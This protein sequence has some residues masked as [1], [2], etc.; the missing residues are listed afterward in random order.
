[1]LRMTPTAR[2]KS[3]G[4]LGS[5]LALALALAGGAVVGT[6]ATGTPAMAQ[7][8][9]AFAKAYEP[10]AGLVN[11]E[12]G[13]PAAAKAGIP[14]VIAAIETADDRNMAGNLVLI[15]GNRLKDPVLQR[16]GLEL[17]LESGKVAPEQIGQFQYLVGS[18]A[19]NAQD[20]AAARAALQAAAAAG[21][22]ADSPEALIAESY[23]GEGQNAQGLQYLRGL[24]DKRAGAGQPVPEAWLVRGLQVAYKANLPEQKLDWSALLVTHSASDKKWLQALQVV[25]TLNTDD[26]QAQLDLLRLMSLTNAMSARSEYVSYIEAADPRIMSNEVAKVLDAAVQAGVLSTG[27]TYYSE[28]KRVVDERAAA[29]RADAP[30]LAAAARSSATA[31]EAQNAGDV[32]LSLGAYAEAEE[33]FALALEKSGVNRDQALTRLGIAQVHQGKYAEA[34]ATLG[35]VSG[36]RT[37]VA[38]MWSAYAET[39]A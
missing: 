22:T 10:V 13:D 14:A 19:Y 4:G 6:A 1:M 36:A 30:K 35:Q 9:K 34:R 25:H 8:S 5:A 20:W 39:R 15:L 17:M 12:G 38:R 3:R 27:D 33:M 29:D 26:R 31:K 28:V 23:F 2:R 24:I 11:A 18:L 32:F 16:Q 7:N 21:Y 37:S